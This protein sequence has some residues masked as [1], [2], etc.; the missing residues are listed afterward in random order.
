MMSMTKTQLNN[1]LRS[2]W[3][4]LLFDFLE[5]QGEDVGLIKDNVFNFPVEILTIL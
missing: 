1:E 2:K 3:T 4:K 5:S